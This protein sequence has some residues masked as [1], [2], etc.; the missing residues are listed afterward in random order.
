FVSSAQVAEGPA[1]RLRRSLIGRTWLLPAVCELLHLLAQTIGAIGELF[2]FGR[3]L[4]RRVWRTCGVALR[5][6]IRELAFA[7]GQVSGLE[8]KVTESPLSTWAWLASGELPLERAQLFERPA[9]AGARAGG[10]LA[11]QITRGTAHLL[12]GVTQ[13]RWVTGSI[14]L[15]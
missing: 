10:I 6:P 4:P 5:H 1:G 11:P 7:I 15:I 8:L 3:V 9:A 14:L 13:P 2:L 12:G